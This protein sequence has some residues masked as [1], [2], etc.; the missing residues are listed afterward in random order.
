MVGPSFCR[1]SRTVFFLLKSPILCKA[2]GVL[3]FLHP[4]ILLYILQGLCLVEFPPWE[5][6]LDLS[7]TDQASFS[8]WKIATCN[9]LRCELHYANLLLCCKE[10]IVSC[11]H[12]GLCVCR[13]TCV[14]ESEWACMYPGNQRP[15]LG[16]VHQEF[17]TI[18]IYFYNVFSCCEQGL[19]FSARPAIQQAPGA[20]LCQF[21]QYRQNKQIL[22]HL[23]FCFLT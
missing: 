23:T 1:L 8:Y 6:S 21:S 2:C 22:P 5:L 18:L 15:T 17:S 4:R 11:V 9:E 7:I 12:S 19:T 16:V 14:D 10:I 3:Y 13:W 20:L